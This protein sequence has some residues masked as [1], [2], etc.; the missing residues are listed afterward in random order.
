MMHN[1][2]NDNLSL[3][4]FIMFSSNKFYFKMK[5][6]LLIALFLLNIVSAFAQVV[7]VDTYSGRANVTIPIYNFQSGSLSYPIML[8]YNSPGM[9]AKDFSGPVGV[10][11]SISS[12]ASIIRNLRGLPDD[13]SS[14]GSP[15]KQGWLINNTCATVGGF[16]PSAD[17]NLN[18]CTDEGGDFNFLNSLGGFSANTIKDTEPDIYYINTPNISG[19]FTFDN[20]GQIALIT[21]R[22]YKITYTQSSNGKIATF[23]ILDEKGITYTFGIPQSSSIHTTTSDEAA[24]SHFKYQYY[25]YKTEV[26]YSSAWRLISMESLNG[27]KILFEYAPQ[28]SPMVFANGYQFLIPS[29]ESEV[30][31]AWMYNE[32]SGGHT[33]VNQYTIERPIRP[34]VQFSRIIGRTQKMEMKNS[35]LVIPTG[36]YTL[37]QPILSAFEIYDLSKSQPV[38]LT[39]FELG[40][41]VVHDIEGGSNFFIFLRSLSQNS[42][43]RS[44]PPYIFD[45][46]GMNL[47]TKTLYRSNNSDRFKDEFGYLN[48][49]V[50]PSPQYKS[51][52]YPNLT[53]LDRIR[54]KPIPAYSGPLFETYGVESEGVDIGGL[55]AGT[56]REITVPRGGTNRIFYEPNIYRDAVAQS[57][58]YAGGLRVNR[59]EYHDGVDFN[60]DI[61]TTYKYEEDN[62]VSSG[63]LLYRP[64]RAFHL[65]SYKNLQTGTVT[66]YHDLVAQNLSQAQLWKK[67]LIKAATDDELNKGADPGIWVG[68]KKTTVS[69]AGAGK[70][71]YEYDIAAPFGTISETG[72]TATRNK[73]ARDNPASGT[74]IITYN[75]GPITGYYSFPF[76]PNPNYEFKQG[77]L[78]KVSVFNSGNNLVE[79]TEN[80]YTYLTNPSKVYAIK[81]DQYKTL[82][83]YN[84]T[85]QTDQGPVTNTVTNEQPMFIYSRYEVN[86]NI[87]PRLLRTTLKTFD[88]NSPSSFITSIQNY[89]Y[90]GTSH[91]LVTKVTQTGSDGVE[92]ST[93]YKYPKDYTITAVWAQQD[94]TS[95]AITKLKDKNSML[96]VE[97]WATKKEGAETP[98]LINANLNIYE[99]DPASDNLYVKR[100]LMV[101]TRDPLSFVSSSI[102]N[103]GRNV[104]VHL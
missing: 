13:Y 100:D 99:Y 82:L 50:P 67:T 94:N 9:K 44:L 102:T 86:T 19:S 23:S 2:R 24:I 70:T 38:L 103:S 87:R 14:S 96:P 16:I 29:T 43:V 27:D 101:S 21:K 37:K 104:F 52:I 12:G 98:L 11:W 7:D 56:L 68:Y 91:D 49:K 48:S 85:L 20:A 51:Y 78:R 59:V 76:A 47:S 63:V 40:Y 3:N 83:T 25:L 61:I 72:W 42:S 88:Q 84:I 60:K 74:S 89:E 55:L 32:A 93:N 80:E 31:R 33:T 81:L 34:A 97:T 69:Q 22:D 90:T 66:Y 73:I 46:Y 17:D 36:D 5:Y 92:Y 30:V 8:H 79:Q 28:M 15:A 10:G 41:E 4:T 57:D 39:S 45:Y 6:H 54:N 95:K 53:G 75:P 71:V 77:L 62:G 58:Y 18:D 65:N 26:V 1:N 64:L 35:T